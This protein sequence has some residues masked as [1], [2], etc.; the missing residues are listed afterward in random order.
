MYMPVITRGDA[1]AKLRLILEKEEEFIEEDTMVTG[2]LDS[3][4]T[5]LEA[6]D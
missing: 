1:A 5:F 3:I 4:L 2:A 6:A